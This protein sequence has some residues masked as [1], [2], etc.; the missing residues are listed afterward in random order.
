MR[1]DLDDGIAGDKD[2]MVTQLWNNLRQYYSLVFNV[3]PR[4]YKPR[5]SLVTHLGKSTTTYKHHK[6]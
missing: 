3:A 5:Y 2:V 4:N 6:F 1:T